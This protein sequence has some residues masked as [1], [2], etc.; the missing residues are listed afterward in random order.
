MYIYVCV[1]VCVCVKERAKERDRDRGRVVC[2]LMRTSLE[3]LLCAIVLHSL[4]SIWTSLTEVLTH[5]AQTLE[6]VLREK[7]GK[8]C[9]MHVYHMS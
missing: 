8:D 4:C 5:V 6:D 7:E 9:C 3:L 1:S 2:P